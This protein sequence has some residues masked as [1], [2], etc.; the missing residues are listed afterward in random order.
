MNAYYMPRP[1]QLPLPL[2]LELLPS[3]QMVLLQVTV[4]PAWMSQSTKVAPRKMA[5]VKLVLLLKLQV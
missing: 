2:V 1:K 5:L 4:P 3:G